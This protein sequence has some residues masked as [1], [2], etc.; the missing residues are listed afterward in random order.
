MPLH[1]YLPATYLAAF[2]PEQT[3][4]RRERLLTIGD[5]ST[6]RCFRAP[7]A[8]V[9]CQ[10][11]YYT[12]FDETKDPEEVDKVWS[13]YEHT[14]A[15]AIEQLISKSINAEDWTRVLV[16]FVSG[17]LVRGPDFEQRFGARLSGLGVSSVSSVGASSDRDNTN[18]ARLFELQRLLAPVLAAKWIVFETQGDGPLITNDIGFA[19]YV[20]GRIGELGIAVPMTLSH[21][22]LLVPTRD[23]VIVGVR[24]GRWVPIIEYRQLHAGNHLKLN[25]TLGRWARRFLFGPDEAA[26]RQYLTQQISPSPVPE[27]G[28]LGFIDGPLAVVHEFTWHRLVGVL[29][30][31]P[32]SEQSWSFELDWGAIAK[33]WCPHIIFPLNLPAFPPSLSRVGNAIRVTFYEVEGFTINRKKQN[34]AG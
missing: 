8:K 21:V 30:K 29:A 5:R 2:S 4:P 25:E 10:R 7:A 19:G 12:L 28:M 16:P 23:R 18:R 15:S 32:E 26:V 22:L 6:G 11:D 14:L 13:E 33:G 24:D 20:D 3:I 34:D 27:P 9:A 17:L 31:H 1:H